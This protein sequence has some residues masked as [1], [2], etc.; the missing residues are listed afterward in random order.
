MISPAYESFVNNVCYD[1]ALEESKIHGM[2]TFFKHYHEETK[3]I[4][5]DNSNYAQMC[6]KFKSNI[7]SCKNAKKAINIC[8]EHIDDLNG[9]IRVAKNVVEGKYTSG[10]SMDNKA[11]ITYMM[12]YLA[13]M[14]AIFGITIAA[15]LVSIPV[16]IGLAAANGVAYAINKNDAKKLNSTIENIQ[17]RKEIVQSMISC[18]NRNGVKS[19]DINR[20]MEQL[21]QIKMPR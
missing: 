11:A 20:Y 1:M 2:I 9:L 17:N 6:A 14:G 18:I 3:E 12:E 8:E 13:E 21:D 7:G 15:P 10:E 4:L 16:N 19:E 5:K